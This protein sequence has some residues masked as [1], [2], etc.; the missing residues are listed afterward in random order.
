MIRDPRCD[1]TLDSSNQC[2]DI[3]NKGTN[4]WRK[5]IDN[6]IKGTNDWRKGIDN[7]RIR[8]ADCWEQGG[9]DYSDNRRLMVRINPTKSTDNLSKCTDDP[10]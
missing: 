10:T 4:D 6:W 7:N 1:G 5:G 9:K 8:G 2:S 3:P